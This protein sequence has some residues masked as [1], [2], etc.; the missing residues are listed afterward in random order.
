MQQHLLK[1]SSLFITWYSL[2]QYGNKLP[3]SENNVSTAERSLTRSQSTFHYSV[4]EDSSD[5]VSLSSTNQN[6]NEQAERSCKVRSKKLVN[7]SCFNEFCGSVLITPPSTP[8][9]EETS[10]KYV[11]NLP[12]EDSKSRRIPWTVEESI[13]LWHGVMHDPGSKNWSQI[14][15]QS[16]RHSN[17]NQVNL[18]DRWRVIHD[19]VTIRNTVRRAYDRWRAQFKNNKRSPVKNIHLPMPII[20]RTS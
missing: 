14:W 17:R 10:R 12:K 11:I 6:C 20:V 13:A 8:A 15:R 16:F 9:P 7:K 5:D 19:N 1:L 3:G 4:T 18:K 2:R